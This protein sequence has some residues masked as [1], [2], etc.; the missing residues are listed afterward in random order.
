M[1]GIVS[2]G[3]SLSPT[4]LPRK[5]ANASEA[6]LAEFPAVTQPYS[7]GQPIKHDVTHHITTTGP[8]ATGRTRRLAPERLKI[9]RQ[10]FNHMLE[11]CIIRPSSSNWAA[12]LHM[13]PK[14]TSGDWRPCGDYRALNR[15]TVPDR[16]P[17]SSHSG[18]CGVAIRSSSVFQD[19]PRQGIS[20][21][22]GRTVR[23]P[24]NCS[25]NTFWSL[26]VPSHAVWPSQHCSILP[27]FHRPST[28]W[29]PPSATLTLMTSSLP[30]RFPQKNT[31]R[32]WDKFCNVSV[33]RAWSWI[34][35]SVSSVSPSSTF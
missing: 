24:E 5:P 14:K 9:A 15:V 17:H 32:I 19:R 6:I 7:I 11:L 20:W 3:I 23:H 16:Y 2:Q 18:L 33:T 13:V 29:P 25:N 26:R 12:P 28:T 10:E 27:T 22:P 31:R 30:V 4:L 1:Q 21:N 8:P 34:R 35:Q